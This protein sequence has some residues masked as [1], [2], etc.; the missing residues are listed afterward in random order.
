MILLGAGVCL[1]LSLPGHMSVDSVEQLAQG[2]AGVYDAL[3]PPVMAWLLGICDA[4]RPGAALFVVLDAVLIAAAFLAFT[5]LGRRSWLTP[6]LLAL[7]AASP[8]LLIYPAIVWKDVLFAA[9][10]IAG[11]ACLAHAAARWTS[12]TWRFGWL[13]AGLLLLVL[14]SLAR[15]N[16]AV[17]LV[18]AALAVGWTAGRAA[19]PARRGRGWAHG[20]AFFL[21]GALTWAGSTVALNTHADGKRASAYQWENLQIYDMVAGLVMEPRTPLP[22]LARRAPGLE[23]TLRTTAVKL[24]R[25]DRIDTLGDMLGPINEDARTGPVVAAQWREFVLHHPLL[26]LRTRAQAFDW[27][28]LTP[29]ISKCLPIY[30]GVDGPDEQMDYLHMVPR[31]SDMDSNLEDYSNL[32]NNTPVFSHAAYAVLA[33][34]LLVVLVRRGRGQDIMVAAMLASGLAFA[35]SFV[36]ISIA[37]DYRYLYFLDLAAMAGAVYAVSSRKPWETAK[38]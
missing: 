21:L 18:F 2:R 22:V 4:I 20:G 23:T 24:Y 17:V 27:V 37:C 33:L 34:G 26:Y 8:L 12:R 13:L 15:Q 1:T 19:S 29:D 36:L 35:A 11:F 38:P 3:H 6:L 32:F 25:P 28:F 10:G 9:S 14:A 5:R 30:V 16:G 31:S 7:F